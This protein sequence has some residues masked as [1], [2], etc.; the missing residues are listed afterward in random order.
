M[1]ADTTSTQPLNFGPLN[2]LSL[3]DAT[4]EEFDMIPGVGRRMV[5]EF[6]E[7]RPYVSIEQFRREIGKYVDADSVAA[8]EKYLYV[9]VD[10]N[11]SDV[12]TLSQIPGMT[13]EF[14]QSLIDGRPYADKVTFLAAVITVTN[15]GVL[16]QFARH[17]IVQEAA[18]QE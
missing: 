17:Y 8:Y 7:Y 1:A 15:D 5:R 12:A 18:V 10:Y 14:A 3:N 11:A 2:K 6:L 13:P 9:P 4:A 16:E